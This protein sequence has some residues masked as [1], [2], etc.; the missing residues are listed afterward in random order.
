MAN[1]I[2]ISD[3]NELGFISFDLNQMWGQEWQQKDGEC[4]GEYVK[5]VE[6]FLIQLRN[7]QKSV[8]GVR[9]SLGQ[10]I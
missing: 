2:I 9:L 7:I 6:T 5:D 4:M 10:K 8:I 3:E 1:R